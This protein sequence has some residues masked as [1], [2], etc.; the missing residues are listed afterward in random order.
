[1]GLSQLTTACTD[2]EGCLAKRGGWTNAGHHVKIRITLQ[3]ARQRSEKIG[4]EIVVD[5]EA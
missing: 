1:M 2:R 5:E 4:N 3:Y